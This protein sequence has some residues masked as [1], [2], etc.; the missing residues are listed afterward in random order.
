MIFFNKDFWTKDRIII[1]SFF[2]V[3]LFYFIS[4]MSYGLNLYDEGVFLYGGLRVLEG[5]LPYKDF[6]FV[7]TPGN[8]YTIA[9]LFKVFGPSIIITRIFNVFILFSILIC[10]YSIVKEELTDKVN[11]FLFFLL[12]TIFLGGNVYFNSVNIPILLSLLSVIFLIR[13]MYNKSYQNLVISGLIAG[14]TCFFRLDF[15]I[16]T[17][18]SISIVLLLNNYVQTKG[19]KSRI[20]SM[21]Q[22]ASKWTLFI[23]SALII[24]I[25]FTIFFLVNVPLNQLYY[26]FIYYPLHIYPIY[27]SLP[28]LPTV[29]NVTGLSFLIPELFPILVFLSVFSGLMYKVFH[30]TFGSNKDWTILLLLLLGIFFFTYTIV[31]ADQNHLYPAFIISIILFSY[32]YSSIGS[33]TL[34]N[35]KITKKN[36][37]ILK[38]VLVYLAIGT[39]LIFYIGSILY[40]PFQPGTPINLDRANGIYVTNQ[41]YLI[42]T[43]NFVQQEIPPSEKIFVGTS[44]TAMIQ[45]N[46]VMFYFLADRGSAT[47]YDDMIT[48]VVTTAPVQQEIIAELQKN[49][50]QYIVLFN[51]S[52]TSNK[53]IGV[54]ILDDYIKNNYQS[55]KVI[56]NYTILKA[57]N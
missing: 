32:I 22:S 44:N 16:Y 46:N 19:L 51:N 2:A 31:R 7:Y 48:G 15:G 36:R 20:K 47:Y 5:Y 30:K 25:P 27:M 33:I 38:F 56:G 43:V 39:V 42:D 37:S 41:N 54:N 49:N 8:L 52:Y 26:L 40:V 17:I 3:A 57:K 6:F 29:Y 45:N 50:V 10:S 35:Q 18:I 11:L 4:L 23:A 53:S 28:F 1:S 9:L 24:V 55:I 13:Y 21:T 12:M 14:L 34:K